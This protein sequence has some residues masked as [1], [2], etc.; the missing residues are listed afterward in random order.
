M[1]SGED[2]E[3]VWSCGE[4]VGREIR[5]VRGGVDKM[6]IVCENV[7]SVWRVCGN[8]ERL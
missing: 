4:Y 1:K 7:E 6:C 3:S 8:I 5:R 2:V